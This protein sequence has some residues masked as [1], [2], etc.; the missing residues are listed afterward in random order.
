MEYPIKK[1]TNEQLDKLFIK[2]K[3]PMNSL[4]ISIPYSYFSKLVELSWYD[5]LFAIENGFL[6]HQSAI[7]HAIIELK[8]NK[9]YSQI[10]IN[11][12]S[13]SPDEAVLRRDLIKQYVNELAKPISDEAKV[14]TKNKVMYILLHWVYEHKEYYEDSLS[15]VELIY[16]DFD[17][18]K[19]IANF[20]R[21]MPPEQPLLSTVEANIERLHK[22]WKD[23]LDK[24]AQYWKK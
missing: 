20:V 7:E 12:A 9:N 17:F 24:Q 23:Y 16:D 2:S 6:S 14:Q 10:V 22:N 18:P 4:M 8:D 13:L 1:I 5:I 11:L 21:Y 19:S 3:L 15:V